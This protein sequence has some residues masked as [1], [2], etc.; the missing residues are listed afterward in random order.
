[1]ADF[2]MGFIGVFIGAI[3]S[4]GSIWFKHYLDTKN[5]KALDDLRKAD[6]K[7]LLENPPP[8]KEWRKLETLA[9]IVGADHATTTRLL[10]EIG[11]RGNEAE[12]DVWAM[13]SD[14]PLN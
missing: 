7:H 2:I 3:V 4:L 5:Q 10:V 12:N 1:M 14:K 11:A 9:R 6:L 13:K 8:G